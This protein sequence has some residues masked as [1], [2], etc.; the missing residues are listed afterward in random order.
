MIKARNKAF[1][2]LKGALCVQNLICYKRKQAEVRRV[3]KS[4]KR[5]YWRKYC[6]TLGR[7]APLEK[8]WT[9]I[10][11]MSGKRK[12]YG[13]PVMKDNDRILV[14][15]RSKAELLARTFAKVHSTENLNMAEIRGREE[16]QRKHLE[17]LQDTE[18]HEGLINVMFSVAELN[19]AFLKVNNTT[20]GR[21]QI[22]YCMIRNLSDPSKSILVKLFNKI[23]E[24]GRLPD[25]WKEA[26][27]VPICKPGKDPALAESFRPIA[28]TSHLGKIMEKMVNERLI[29]FLETNNKTKYY[30]SGFRKGRSTIDPAVRLEH[31]IRR[32]QVN[33]ESVVV[34]FLDV[35]KAYD[36]ERRA[37]DQVASDWY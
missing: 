19:N 13:Y 8:V 36:V 27:I 24:E 33:R 23:W 11:K 7:S 9:T 18:E 14:D 22:S 16:T 12:E 26:V 31:E 32:A 20:P 15:N 1:K 10:K 4:A 3:V 34:V 30:Q 28:L 29:Y 35:E 37:P 25:Q 6:D 2:T 5:E 17:D 21:D